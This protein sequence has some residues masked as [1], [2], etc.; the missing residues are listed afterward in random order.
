MYTFNN[1]DPSKAMLYTHR[2]R[3]KRIKSINFVTE[4]R[5]SIP[6]C[7]NIVIYIK[8]V[9][10]NNMRTSVYSCSA[11]VDLDII[12][13]VMHVKVFIFVLIPRFLNENIILFRGV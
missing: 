5:V 7:Y 8:E 13:M 12:T 10:T 1:R 9:R 3:L 4:K 6:L 2:T 11:I